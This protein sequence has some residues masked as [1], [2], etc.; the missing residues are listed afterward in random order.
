MVIHINISM[1]ESKN[2]V[3]T[4]HI[5]QKV[6]RYSYQKVEL[7]VDTLIILMKSFGVDVIVTS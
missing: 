3:T 6:K 2:P 4:L 5:T 1:V 7:L